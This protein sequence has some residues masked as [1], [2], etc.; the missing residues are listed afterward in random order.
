MTREPRYT[1]QTDV[2][3]S[4]KRMLTTNS[5]MKARGFAPNEWDIAIP[6][7][8][9]DDLYDVTGHNPA[10]HIVTLAKDG[11]LHPVTDDGVVWLLTYDW[12]KA[13]VYEVVP[14]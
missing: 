7:D 11:S 8:T 10:G 6:Q 4:M 1:V 3:A 9:Y 14:Q 5:V 12:A 2:M 13:Q